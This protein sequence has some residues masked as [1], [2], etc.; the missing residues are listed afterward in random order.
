[1]GKLRKK[2]TRPGMTTSRPP[3]VGALKEQ[4]RQLSIDQLVEIIEKFLARLGEKERLEFMNL[5]PS[6]CSEDLERQLPY[7]RDEDF[8]EAIED[9]C[10]RVRNEEFVEYGAGYDPDE[11]EYHGFGDDSWI[12]EMDA[13]FEA[14]EL[15]FLARRYGIAEKAYQLLFA[16]LEIESEEGGYYFT[17]SDPQ[18]ALSTDLIKARKHYFESLCRLYRGET[19]AGTIIEGLGEYY[20]IG[21]KPPNLQELFPEGGEVIRLLEEALIKRPSRDDAG[22]V[23]TALDHPAELLRQIYTDF[24]SLEELDRFARQ[25]GE[26]HPWCYED[27]VRAYAQKNDWQKVFFWA[28]QGLSSKGSQKKARNAILA[29]HRARAAQQ[30]GDSTAV[31]SALWEAFNSEANVERYV[32]LRKGAKAQGQW[33]EYYPRLTQRLTHDISGSSVTLGHQWD[34]RLLVEALLVE[35]EYERALERAAQPHFTSP[36][37]EKGNARKSMVDFFLHSV[38]RAADREASATQY[39]EIT[40]RLNQPSEFIKQT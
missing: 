33:S 18:G 21:K 22:T 39:P 40:R 26:K 15:Y 19:L 7:R 16:C 28:S 31:L 34:N 25:Y 20:Y 24:R 3:E 32:A 9:F 38:T 14:A 30:L 13:L 5:L 2:T 27:L 11:G 12:E 29:D 1:M 17:T 6:V 35:G 36:W 4:L 8:L 23:L 10:E 37:D